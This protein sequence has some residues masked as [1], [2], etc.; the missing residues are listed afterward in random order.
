MHPTFSWSKEW[1][2]KAPCALE[3]AFSVDKQDWDMSAR[4]GQN[5]AEFSLD[6]VLR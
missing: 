1:Q 3:S 6:E 4:V 5:M 2:Q